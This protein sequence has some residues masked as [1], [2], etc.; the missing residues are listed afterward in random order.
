MNAVGTGMFVL[1]VVSDAGM[2]GLLFGAAGM[3]L[4]FA[5][6]RLVFGLVC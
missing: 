3:R 4:R 1:R 2:S 6:R 5:F